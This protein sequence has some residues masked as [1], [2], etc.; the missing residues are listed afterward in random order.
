MRMKDIPPLRTAIS[1]IVFKQ[2]IEKEWEIHFTFGKGGEGSEQSVT[3]H[4][5]SN[6]ART[7]KNLDSA[8][9]AAEELFGRMEEITIILNPELTYVE[10]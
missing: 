7:W 10:T 6:D 4:Y 5:P 9:G 8:F 1:K 2:T 3:K